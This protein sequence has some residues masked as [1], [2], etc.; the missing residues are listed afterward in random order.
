MNTCTD[1]TLQTARPQTDRNE[2]D[3][4]RHGGR[5]KLD[6]VATAFE[7][8]GESFG[9]MHTLKHVNYSERG[10]GALSDDEVRCGTSIAVGFQDRNRHAEFEIGRAHV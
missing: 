9:G 7:L 8:D 1:T 5:W 4:R 10:I 6:G 2:T 3:E